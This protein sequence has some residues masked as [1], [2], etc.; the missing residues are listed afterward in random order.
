MRLLCLRFCAVINLVSSFLVFISL[1][2]HLARKSNSVSSDK[3]VAQVSL[4]LATISLIITYISFEYMVSGRKKSL[5]L[6]AN[7]VTLI[8]TIAFTLV[9]MISTCVLD[10]DFDIR[11][12]KLR[13]KQDFGFAF[14]S[15]FFSCVILA[16]GTL[17]SFAIT[18]STSCLLDERKI[19]EK[20]NF[21]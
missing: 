15:N 8:S 17:V 6:R 2:L 14:K 12:E 10:D 5:L 16:I 1:F 13:I 7:L 3:I 11:K 21:A 19:S 20:K 9:S 4:A 18:V